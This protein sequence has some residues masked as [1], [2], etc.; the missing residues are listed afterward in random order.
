MDGS[1][2]WR[3]VI[4]YRQLIEKSV[5]DAY[6]LPLISDILDKIEEA[7][8]ISVFD[9]KSGFYHCKLEEKD[10]QWIAFIT[11]QGL[12]EMNVL[13]F[14]YLNSPAEFQKFTN[15]MIEPLKEFT[16]VYIDDILIFFNTLEEHFRHIFLFINRC[17]EKGLVLGKGKSKV[18]KTEIEF[19]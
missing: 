6:T 8:Y 18:A 3:I 17:E 12:Y 4:D 11:L 2:S 9:L 1:K 5:G 14:G 16:L 10:K 19:L 7:K 15:M 13:L